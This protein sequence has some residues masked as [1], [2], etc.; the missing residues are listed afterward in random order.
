[1]EEK[2]SGKFVRVN[3]LKILKIKDFSIS[4]H[5]LKHKYK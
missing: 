2:L 5:K 4:K 3:P 1:M